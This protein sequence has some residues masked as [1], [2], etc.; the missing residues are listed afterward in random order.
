[1]G[2]LARALSAGFTQVLSISAQA[3]PCCIW[4]AGKRNIFQFVA[5]TNQITQ[6][7]RFSGLCSG[8]AETILARAGR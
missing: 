2:H 6:T 8:Q 3:G 1:M 4:F 7:V 5:G